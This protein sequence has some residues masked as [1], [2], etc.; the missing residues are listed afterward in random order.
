M[1]AV[2]ALTIRLCCATAGRRMSIIWRNQVHASS[3]FGN[4]QP[5]YV[6]LADLV[7]QHAVES[8]SRRPGAVLATQGI[9]L[10]AGPSMPLLLHQ[11]KELKS[12][13]PPAR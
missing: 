5:S 6:L 12:W 3:V 7:A 4:L 2:S 13:S 8:C 11:N 1:P 10:G 9:C